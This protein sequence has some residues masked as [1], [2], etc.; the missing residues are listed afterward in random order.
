MYT[1]HIQVKSSSSKKYP[2]FSTSN[3]ATA[4][5]TQIWSL[6]AIIKGHTPIKHFKVLHMITKVMIYSKISQQART[7]CYTALTARQ[8][9]FQFCRFRNVFTSCAPLRKPACDVF[10]L[11][12]HSCDGKTC[13]EQRGNFPHTLGQNGHMLC[14]FK[15]KELQNF[16]ED[17]F[18]VKS[19]QVKLVLFI[20]I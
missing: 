10:L 5:E 20:I 7:L 6:H 12:M 2:A 16:S 14:I 17:S 1:M 13:L 8:S 18:L 4:Q 9:F 11:S 19:N 3:D 15:T